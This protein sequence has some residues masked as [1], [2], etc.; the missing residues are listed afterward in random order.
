M[1]VEIKKSVLEGKADAPSSKSMTHRALI[2]GSLAKGKTTILSPLDSQDTQATS[3]VL[4]HLGIKQEKNRKWIIYGGDFKP[5]GKEL[6]CGESGTTIRF[7]TA[8]SALVDGKC[9]L[10]GG[11]GLRRRPIK[12]LVDAVSQ[13]GVRA[14]SNHG[15]PPVTIYGK[16][17]I[18][19]GETSLPGDISSQFVSALLLVSPL[20]ENPVKIKISNRLESKPYVDMTLDA[21]KSFGVTAQKESDYSCLSAPLG[22]YQP[23]SYNVEGDWS[24]AAFLLASGALCGDVTV[25]NLNIESPQADRQIIPILEEMGAHIEKQRSIINATESQLKGIK[26]DMRDYPDLFPIVAALCSKAEGKSTLTGLKRLRIKESDRIESMV[27]GLKQ[28]GAE[29]TTE[30]NLLWIKGG[31]LRGTVI[32]PFNDH[33]IAMSFGVLGMVANGKTI[34]TNSECVKKSYPGFWDC[35]ERLGA[36]IRRDVNE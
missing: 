18:P 15:Y 24:S 36:N 1:N 5:P 17:K 35:I 2:L 28:M 20:A 34:I 22:D 31:D 6:F 8:V 32:D 30:E 27:M 14:D 25:R 10:D 4:E 11:G 26:Y 19:G 16:G 33:R 3:K 7:M 13:I 29:V 21:M 9:V 12:S 23:I